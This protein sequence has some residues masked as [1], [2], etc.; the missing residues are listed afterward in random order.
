MHCKDGRVLE[1]AAT[2]TLAPGILSRYTKI[3]RFLPRY[4]F[5]NTLPYPLRLWQDSSIF[6]PPASDSTTEVAASQRKW[7]SREKH[8]RSAKKVNQYETL[9]GRETVLDERNVGIIPGGTR[10]HPSALYITSVGETEVVPFNLPDSRGERQLRI[11]LGGVWNLTASVSAD[12]QGEYT[13]N[14][15]R[16]VDLKM[17]PHVSTRGSPEFEVR[18]NPADVQRFTNELGIWFETEW[19][20]DRKLIIKAVKKG[21]FAFQETDVHVGDELLLID[22]DP[23]SQMTFSEVM[24][25]LRRRLGEL[26][27]SAR[28]NTGRVKRRASLSFVGIGAKSS[29]SSSQHEVLPLKLMFRTVEERLRRVR[30]KAARTQQGMHGPVTDE[31]LAI[32][33]DYSCY[34]RPTY[35]KVELREVQ[36]TMFFILR[37]QQIAPYQI[38]NRTIN[39]TIYYRQKGCD[40]YAWQFLKPGQSCSYAWE[41]PLRPKRLT[42]RVATGSTLLSDGNT[43]AKNSFKPVDIAGPLKMFGE[44][45]TSAGMFHKNIKDEKD[46]VFSPSISVRLEEIGFKDY[47]PCFVHREPEDDLSANRFLEL[48]VDV[49]GATRVL[50]VQDASTS[51]GIVQLSQHLKLLGMK[52][53][54]VV[55]RQKALAE[56]KSSLADIQDNASDDEIICRA[57]ELMDNDFQ[58][59]NIITRCHQLVVEIVEANGLSPD[60]FVGSC[61]PYAEVFL[62]GQQIKR[63]SLFKKHDIRQTYY[64]SKTVS[65]TWQSQTFVFDVPE[66][67]ITESRGHL[68]KVRLRNFRSVGYHTNLGAAQVELHCIRDQKSLTGWF[69]L[70]GRTGRQELE[71]LSNWARG[72]IKMRL[73]WIY[74]TNALLDYFILLSEK[75]LLDLKESFEGMTQQL[76]NKRAAEAKR[77]EE[78][79]G[80]TRVRMDDLVQLSGHLQKSKV[81]STGRK[82]DG[83]ELI[84]RPFSAPPRQLKED[85][86]SSRMIHTVKPQRAHSTLSGKANYGKTTARRDQMQNLENLISQRRRDFSDHLGSLHD[87]N[88]K[89][90]SVIV[91]KGYTGKISVSSFKTWAAAQVLIRDSDFA[92]VAAGSALHFS[93]N[94][95]HQEKA[96]VAQQHFESKI[97]QAV[98]TKLGLPPQATGAMAVAAEESASA[99][100]RSRKSFERSAKR[101]VMSALHPGGWLVVRPYT[102]LNLSDAYTGMFV[103]LRHGPKIQTTETVDARVCPT[104]TRHCPTGSSRLHRARKNFLEDNRND[105]HIHI[106][107]QKTSGSL[108]LSVVG[109]RSHDV[110]HS[111]TELGVLHLPLGATISACIDSADIYNDCHMYDPLSAAK[112]YMRWF[113][114]MSPIDAVPVEGDLGLSIRP[115]ETEKE[116]D[117]SFH[118]Y[119]APCIQLA[120]F[121]LPDSEGL[122]PTNPGGTWS[123]QH[124]GSAEGTSIIASPRVFHYYIA[125]IGGVSAALI[126]SQRAFELFSLSVSN[127]ECRFWETKTKTRISLSIGWL[128]V[129]QQDD[130][131]REPVILAPTPM[132]YIE[133]VVQVL[134]VMD[135]ARTMAEVISFDFI[136]ISIAEYDLTLEENILFSM[137]DF[138]TS[139]QLRK[140]FMVRSAQQGA[141]NLDRVAVSTD[142]KSLFDSGEGDDRPHLLSNLLSSNSEPVSNQKIYIEQLVL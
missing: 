49:I 82:C 72:S 63:Q 6:R 50:V 134:A 60:S 23:I 65:P 33:S 91:Q 123:S 140:G 12:L 18:M 62:K 131:A 105:L 69:P 61:N 48:E 130:D 84:A 127:I 79:D 31:D 64:V 76:A 3:V 43:R 80:F 116:T 51:N 88:S 86:S 46:S 25:R 38:Q 55:E 100:L 58:E 126:E 30:L 129:D 108:V 103:R 1:L 68:V 83:K 44:D 93:L 4:L 27:E 8:K 89:R 125:D 28:T 128:Q 54:E 137:F 71:T 115:P 106:A 85:L 32:A 132:G 139:V 114:L 97:E 45:H 53:N 17:T 29:I 95:D 118:D 90:S 70:T 15:T 36:S 52:C 11:D 102:V 81:K 119:F 122:G 121:W 24:A 57:Q 19:Q 73:Q 77:Q 113:P 78:A 104:W 40:G 21:S 124:T 16:A 10:A 20:N 96:E 94:H 135:N 98:S 87:L 117:S 37:E 66:N 141:G 120:I 56:L 41:E 101:K 7:H 133:P 9:F 75:Q 59:E 42:V 26:S 39:S 138:M 99:Y 109:E 5:V 112:M 92:I 74:K 107:P 111:K 142:N 2:V 34:S 14:V 67:A 110:V 35:L 22:G 136:D 47:L 13:L